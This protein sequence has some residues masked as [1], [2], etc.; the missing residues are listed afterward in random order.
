M[1]MFLVLH[2][3]LGHDR[4]VDRGLLRLRLRPFVSVWV[5]DVG[6]LMLRRLAGEV[7]NDPPK[8]LSLQKKKKKKVKK[9]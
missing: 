7:V 9:T 2:C 8:L 1:S 5:V 3:I 6:W 4:G